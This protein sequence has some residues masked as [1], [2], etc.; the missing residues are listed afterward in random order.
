M[1]GATQLERLTYRNCIR[2]LARVG[3]HRDVHPNPTTRPLQYTNDGPMN[4][5][6]YLPRKGIWHR[7]VS[8]DAP[9]QYA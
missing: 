8:G 9:Q 4:S 2:L 7:K 5:K 1:I 6:W 3:V